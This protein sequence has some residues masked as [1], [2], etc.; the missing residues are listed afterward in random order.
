MPRRLLTG[1]VEN[2][3]AAN[4]GGLFPR[5]FA[6]HLH[7]TPQGHQRYLVLRL[8]IFF[9]NSLG[10]KPREK[11]MTPT[12]DFLAMRKWPSSW[13]KIKTPKTMMVAMIVVITFYLGRSIVG[14]LV[15]PRHGHGGYSPGCVV[16]SDGDG[17]WF[18][19][20]NGR[21]GGIPSDPVKRPPQPLHWRH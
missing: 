4:S 7:V 6:D 19:R 18:C 15:W 10:P 13:T 1:W 3:L 9:P 17:P 5:L 20:S 16:H 11:V 14:P 12:F 8:P 2:D 21:F